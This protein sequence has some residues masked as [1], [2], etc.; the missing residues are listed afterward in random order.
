MNCLMIEDLSNVTRKLINVICRNE[1]FQVRF[2]GQVSAYM[3]V[4][5][6]KRNGS[7]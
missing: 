2:K 1:F 3:V 6:A 5:A 7:H 4:L